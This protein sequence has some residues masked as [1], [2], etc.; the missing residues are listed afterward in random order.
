MCSFYRIACASALFILSACGGEKEAPTWAD[1][2]A[3][4]DPFIGTDG[5]GYNQGQTFVGPT[6]PFG[7]V[8]PG[9]DSGGFLPR[10]AASWAHTSGYWYADDEI[11][12]FSQLHFSGTGIED[13]G[14]FLFMPTD[15]MNADKT[16][17]GGYQEKFSHDDEEAS[18]GHYG[19]T[20]L[21]SRIRVDLG[22]SAHAAH[23]RYEFPDSVAEPTVLVD[24]SHGV[25]DYPAL[26]G[27][28]TIDPGANTIEGWMLSA[29]RFTGEGSAFKVFFS[30]RFSKPFAGHGVWQDGALSPG[31][32]TTEGT[33][34]GAW[35][36]FDAPGDVE[37]KIGVSYIDVQQAR[38]NRA[39][40]DSQSLDETRQKAEDA[41][42]EQLG[43]IEILGGSRRQQRIFYTALYH[44]ALMPTQMSE[45]DRYVGLDR[46]VHTET[47]FTYYS[48]MSMWDTY[49]TLHPLMAL[50]Y[51]QRARDFAKTLLAMREQ[52]GK[53]VRWPLAVNETGTMVG[54]P[55]A[56]ILADTA[57][58]GVTDFDLEAALTSVIQDAD[59]IENI[60]SRP[61]PC[62]EHGYCPSDEVGRATSLTLEYGWADFAIANF[63]ESLGKPELAADFRER[64]ASYKQH[65]DAENGFLRGINTDGS[66]AIRNFDSQ[67]QSDDYV[68]GNAWHYLWAV[69]FDVI[70]ESE[71]FGGRQAFVD[72]LSEF[73][74]TSKITPTPVAGIVTMP[75][76]YY[77]H[78]NEPDIHAAFLFALAGMPGLGG[79][80]VDWIRE[81]RYDD[82][83]IGLAGNDDAGTLSAWYVFASLGI[84]PLAGSDIYVLSPPVWNESILHLP[85]GDLRIVAKRERAGD[86]VLQGATLNGVA[87]ENPW[88]AHDALASGGELVLEMSSEPSSWIV[89][90]YPGI[91]R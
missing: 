74:E 14:N 20:F 52:H 5:M 89:A 38:T 31:T 2:V 18:P 65:W 54:S 81:T 3:S 58:R 22:A 32:M 86:L 59:G 21:E 12:G 80:W 75:D 4:V 6:L 70:G 43:A 10:K 83:P 16:T 66:W 91:V 72:R 51:P 29:G 33:K 56:I 71:L 69:P 7:M 88:V 79:Q 17:E 19:V 9:P 90:P 30:A 84:Y 68:E 44:A 11:E 61:L 36:E 41:W 76:E 64:A 15:G 23:H 57:L 28:V 82:A 60:T 35:V 13:Y 1:P 77:W 45:G 24:I 62:V 85:G 37:V 8:K 87:L 39:E 63:A 34:L 67:E 47:G 78:G 49:R 46:S 40:L 42:K 73:F 26:D 48:D 55:A 50:V 53:L 27:G 25:G